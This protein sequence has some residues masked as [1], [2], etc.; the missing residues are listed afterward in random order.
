MPGTPA[1]LSNLHARFGRLSWQQLFEEAAVRAEDGFIVSPRM[2]QSI[3]SAKGL[4]AYE[5]TRNYFFDDLGGPL[6][7][8]TTLKNP[9]MAA[10]LRDLGENGVNSFYSGELS[11]RIIAA[12][13]RVDPPSE[14][15]ATDF[16]NYQVVERD[17]I[18]SDY[19]QWQV[20]GMGPPSSGALTVSQILGMVE[21][22]DLPTLGDSPQSWHVIAEASR[23]A[24]A[25]RA[26]YMADSDF[27]D[28]PVS[29]LID[30][31]YL[32]SRAALIEEER[33]LDSVEAGQPPS[34]TRLSFAPD[35]QT[36]RA[37]TSHFVIVDDA[38]NMVSMTTTIE[39]G[40]GSRV[41]AE[42][43][44][45]NNELTDFSFR[46]EHDGKAIANRIEPGKRPRSSMAP[47]MVFRDGE[48]VL[49]IGSPGGSRIIGYV[50]NAL[51]GILDWG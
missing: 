12:A 18:C 5:E 9:Q 42:G 7:A 38:G 36:E 21:G 19:R 28:V 47:T 27:V 13:Q 4:D 50:V 3:A 1:L 45:L 20:C 24:Y 44:L 48:P 17:P 26:L 30:P 25:D 22:F 32:R 39:T 43:L 41:M 29:G 46:A 14:L 33:A 23:L 51:V 49:L 16:A 15:T 37:G 34:D 8:G 35:L 10:T 11:R 40:F 6:A 31:A 2:A